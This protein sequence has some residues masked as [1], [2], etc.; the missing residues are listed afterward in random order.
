MFSFGAGK[1]DVFYEKIPFNSI[2]QS[3]LLHF[4]LWQLISCLR[5]S[6]IGKDLQQMLQDISYLL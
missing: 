2:P 6:G 1:T 5:I 4:F 3:S